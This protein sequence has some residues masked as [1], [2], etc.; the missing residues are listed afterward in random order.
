M[1]AII[2]AGAFL[3][4][5]LA[6]H[7]WAAE[8]PP[9]QDRL[10][11]M[12]SGAS[13]SGIEDVSGTRIGGS[14]GSGAS[15]SWLHNFNAN[16]IAGIGAE[17]QR[18]DEARWTMGVLNLAY[19]VGQANSR[20]NFY[21]EGK[22]GSGED[23]VH[24]FTYAMYTVG[25]IQNVTRQF[26]ILIE[27]KQVDIDTTH[28]NLPKLGIQY[29]WSPSLLTQAA[30]AHSLTDSLGTRLWSA[31]ADYYGKKVNLF[32]GGA[33]GHASPVVINFQTGLPIPGFKTHEGFVGIT[34][35]FSRA[36]ITVL[37]DY[38]K[39]GDLERV[40]LTLNG[41]VRLGGPAR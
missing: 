15:I 18:I 36:D 14:D 34:K 39:I 32:A 22:N 9:A 10:A 20:S 8:G 41:I 4:F 31:R 17:H 26:A 5:L 6:G 12:V 35:P 27:D 30:Y 37:A 3:S 7:A 21:F 24:D 23:D 11:L 40:T 16:T 1:K 33:T 13:L 25:L 29:L 19:G 38:I 2:S 28:G